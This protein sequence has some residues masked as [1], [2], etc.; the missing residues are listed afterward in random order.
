[1]LLLDAGEPHDLWIDE[2]EFVNVN[3]VTGRKGA[4]RE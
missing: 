1:M 3:R 4:A 2:K